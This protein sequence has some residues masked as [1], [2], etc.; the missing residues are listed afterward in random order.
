[1]TSRHSAFLDVI[2]VTA[3]AVIW[4]DGKLLVQVKRAAD[5]RIYLGLP[6]G[7]L[8]PGETLADAACREAW[9]E[10]GAR[11][12]APELVRVAEIYKSRPEGLRHQVEHL[13]VCHVDDTYVPQMGKQPD[14]KQ[15][16]VRWADPVTE[17][18]LFDPP[19][20][21]LLSDKTAGMYQGVI[22]DETA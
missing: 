8:E 3:R 4:R 5:G 12:T 15:I 21:A 2:R 19:Y 11:V 10:T 20:A 22:Q 14:S 18:A 13:F 17:A 6:G 7:R 9:E 1:M 16:G